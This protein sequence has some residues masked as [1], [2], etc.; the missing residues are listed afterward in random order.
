[1]DTSIIQNNPIN[2]DLNNP[3]NK[4]IIKYQRMIANRTP[5][6]DDNIKPTET[7][8]ID[9][10]LNIAKE[11]AISSIPIYGTIQSFKKGEIGWGIF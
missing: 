2:K 5:N 9:N 11:A 10:I 8:V 4:D 1:M 7:P 6:I 3:I